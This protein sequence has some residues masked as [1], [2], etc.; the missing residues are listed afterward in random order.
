[1]VIFVLMGESANVR[2]TSWGDA[3]AGINLSLHWSKITIHLNLHSGRS[4]SSWSYKKKKIPDTGG[5][6]F[7]W[8]H[9]SWCV[10]LITGWHSSLAGSSAPQIPWKKVERDLSV[11]FV[12]DFIF[13]QLLILFHFCNSRRSLRKRLLTP[14]EKRLQIVASVF[15]FVSD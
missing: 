2:H 12:K 3:M 1:M 4:T 10:N 5:R 15:H 13:Q 7:G 14:F 6:A 8:A 11:P 9:H